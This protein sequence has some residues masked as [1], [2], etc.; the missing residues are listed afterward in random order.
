MNMHVEEMNDRLEVYSRKENIL[1]I[2]AMS[3]T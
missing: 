2:V 1:N 3:S